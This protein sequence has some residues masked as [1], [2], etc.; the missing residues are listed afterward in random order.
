MQAGGADALRSDGGW[1]RTAQGVGDRDG[2]C[3]AW[4]GM[5]RPGSAL[6]VTR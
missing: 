6:L 2:F 5:S 4:G 3:W 1:E